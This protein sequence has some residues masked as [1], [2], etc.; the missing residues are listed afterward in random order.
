MASGGV[1]TAQRFAASP[2]SGQSQRPTAA[3]SARQPVHQAPRNISRVASRSKREAV[4]AARADGAD[5][6]WRRAFAAIPAIIRGLEPALLPPAHG[7]E[8]ARQRNN[9]WNRARLGDKFV[10]EDHYAPLS[11]PSN[12]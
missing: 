8:S 10:S 4:D 12:K 7:S 9:S 5:T 1:A 3:S 6:G 11:V 2:A